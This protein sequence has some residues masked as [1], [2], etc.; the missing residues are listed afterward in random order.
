MLLMLLTNILSIAVQV[1]PTALANPS[2]TLEISKPIQLTTS[3]SYDRN[4]SFLKAS[5]GTWWLFFS[6]G[7][8]TGYPGPNPDADFYDIVYMKSTDNGAT[9]TEYAPSTFH[10]PFSQI[11][12]S[13]IQDHT[14][15]IWV[16]T[17]DWQSSYNYPSQF[18]FDIYYYTSNDGG[19]TWAGP[20]KLL[21]GGSDALAEHVD[22]L[23]DSSNNLWVFFGGRWEVGGTWYTKSS[24][25]GATW[26]AR[27]SIPSS[28]VIPKVTKV[29]NFHVVSTD[30]NS[31]K[32]S[33]SPDGATWTTNTVIST[34]YTDCDPVIYQDA[35]GNLEVFY[36]PSN[37]ALG[38]QW[39]E[40]MRSSDGGTTW[41]CRTRLTAGG[42][43]TTY[44]WDMWPEAFVDGSKVYL[45]YTSERSSNGTTRIDGNIWMYDVIW[46]LK[47]DHYEFIQAAINAASPGDT[48]IV[49]DGTYPEALYIN[50]SLTIKAA[51]T[52]VIKGSRLFA[53][54]YGNREA[55]IFVK[56]A[57]VTLESLDIEGEGLGPG[58]IKSYGILYQNSNGSVISC[59]VSPN[60]VGDMYSTG[61]AAISRSNLLISNSVIRNFGRVGVYATNVEN[62]TIYKNE[63]I[64]QVYNLDNLV[65][66]GIE[67]E[68]WD[69]ASTAQIVENRIYNSNNTHPSP[70]WSSAAI[71]M[72]IWRMFYELS[73]STV[74]VE[75]NEIY[76]NYEAIQVVSNPSLYAHYNNIYNNAYGVYVDSDLHNINET[77]DARFNWW[78]DPT[79][80]THSSNAGGVGDSIG[81]YVDYSPWLG[82]RYD[83]TPRTYHVNPAGAPSA[84]QEAINEANPG[85]TIIVHDGI[86]D[87]QVVVDKSLILQGGSTPIVKPSSADKLATIL[88]GY[89][90]G[91][92]K[93]I[94]GIIVANTAG[95]SVTVKNLIVDGENVVTKPAGADYVAGIFY[96]ETGGTIDTVTVTNM[97]I[98]ATG[99]A[100][101]GYGIYLSAIANAVSVEVKGSTITNYD[102]NGIDAHGNELTVNIHHN[103]LTGRGPLPSGDEVQNGIVIMD[104]AAG[105]V[106]N[107]IVSDMAYIPETWWTAGIMFLAGGSVSSANGNTVNDCQ[108]GIAFNDV[109]GS[110]ADN[111][112]S[113]GTA[114]KAGLFLQQYIASGTW[115]ASFVNNT[116]SGCNVEGIG[117]HSYDAG[118]SLTVTIENNKLMDGLGDGVYIGDIPEYSPAGSITVTISSNFISGWHH[119]IHLVSSV[120]SANITSNTVENNVL[121]DS[122]IHIEAAV[123][124]SK[125][126]VH[127]NN[128]EGNIAYGIF[129]GGTGILDARYNWW[130][131]QSGPYHPAINPTG[132]GDKVSDYVSFIPWLQVIH[133]VA[134]ID[135]TVSPTT[136]VAGQT[137][138]IN[139][140]VKN[141]GS[142]YENFTVTA[143]Y[144]STA[145]ASQNVTSLL[146]NWNTTLTFLWNT[147]GMARGNYTIKAVASTVPGEINTAN[148]VFIDGQ[149]QVLWHDVAVVN[150]TSDRNWVFQG[151]SANINVTVKNNGDFPE[152][153]TVT[154]YYNI[155][156]NEIVGT[157]NIIL[158]IGESTTLQF[159][160]NTAGV[161]YCHNYTLTAVAAILADNN[162]ADNTLSDG[163]IKVRILGDLNGDGVIDM[164]DIRRVAV[165]FASY[166][167]YPRWDPEADLNGDG[168]VDMKDT[169]FVAK[170]FGLGCSP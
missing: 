42:Y 107:N 130:G 168:V 94:A 22:A 120:A 68:D 15:K 82:D 8:A 164:K 150:I 140:T 37:D 136:V 34:G 20:T 166:P 45:F 95:G 134:V 137:V 128:I 36:A 112:V 57:E 152:N 55:V 24:D 97:T 110:A 116:V 64:G 72:D 145:I 79:G 124:A 38:S 80:P 151:H 6:R 27:A 127:Y 49:H 162:P 167:G 147:T 71:I 101:R 70:L 91:V 25:G 143:Y 31:I 5:D 111:I 98:G 87:E 3:L 81:D 133:D 153:V 105:T 39:I 16:F 157:Q 123:D 30:W 88:D 44:W 129:N 29:G 83:I 100:V 92:T 131:D 35:S 53:T 50:K 135:V 114:G 76:D 122:G 28:G 58:P 40:S 51:S 119:G 84:I 148:N 21:P 161:P 142:D 86:Y 155:T 2:K 61:V 69:G 7:N 74:S 56:D 139:V 106:N 23:E 170:N 9:W 10:Q 1:I 62:I 154:L 109:S 60:T 115:T 159:V 47:N 59:M 26:S 138:T 32:H 96:R 93:Q 104:G 117:A 102:K 43:G 63:I 118:T 165:A 67:I 99:T 160:W 132:L 33:S 54:D 85:D 103:T 48:I 90:W 52:P 46:D 126:Q 78:G 113:G 146:P 73:P 121:V 66:Y 158:L 19:M 18:T 11:Q 156:A 169:R 41:S 163:S 77:F 144:D 65:N 125:V 141:E 108:I 149:V 89:W 12:A 14:G 17:S 13:A 4:P 75:F